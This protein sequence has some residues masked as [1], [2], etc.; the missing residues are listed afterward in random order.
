MADRLPALLAATPTRPADFPDLTARENQILN[1][2]AEG[3]DNADIARELALS[4]NTV[5]NYR[6]Q[7]PDQARSAGPSTSRG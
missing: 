6:V 1:L 2:L 3:R 4:L 5:R 7:H